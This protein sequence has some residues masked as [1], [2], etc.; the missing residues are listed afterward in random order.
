[1]LPLGTAFGWPFR[2]LQGALAVGAGVGAARLLRH[3]RHA[4]WVVPLA[5]VA[6]RLLLDPVLNAYYLAALQGPIFVGAAAGASRVIGLRKVRRGSREAR[7]LGQ[8]A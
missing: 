2:I 1:V 5:V 4:L 8:N 3:S 7:P 6:A